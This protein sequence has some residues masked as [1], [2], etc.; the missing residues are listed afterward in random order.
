V[1]ES[2]LAV[3][4]L[5]MALR[6]NQWAA[7]RNLVRKRTA[8]KDD[9]QEMA[10]VLNGHA[11]ELANDAQQVPAKFETALREVMA[12][13][14]LAVRN[15]RNS[16]LSASEPLEITS[17]QL[18]AKRPTFGTTCA[19]C[20]GQTD[21]SRQAVVQLVTLQVR[22]RSEYRVRVAEFW[23]GHTAWL[24]GSCKQA[25]TGRKDLLA[26]SRELLQEAIRLSPKS[27]I[28][29]QNLNQVEQGL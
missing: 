20:K 13:V 17:R 27:T 2:K 14:E 11:V 18:Q 28:I 8:D 7:A 29:R 26:R 19:V 6:D 1:I 3:V 5:E 25:W 4:E 9:S 16:Y 23:D 10:M 12:A 21:F 22:G 15:L 24:C